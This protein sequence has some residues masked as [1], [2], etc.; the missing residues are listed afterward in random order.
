MAFNYAMRWANDAGL[1]WLI[2]LWR[3][4]EELHGDIGLQAK[5][6]RNSLQ[7][8]E[9]NGALPHNVMFTT[10]FVGALYDMQVGL[11]TDG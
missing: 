5:A 3:S 1:Y 2:A 11:S 4:L 7:R 10:F 6:Y 9:C 8:L